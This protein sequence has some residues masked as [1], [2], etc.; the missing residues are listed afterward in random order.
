MKLVTELY[1]LVL[2]QKRVGMIRN[3]AI[4]EGRQYDTWYVSEV[5][6][7]DVTSAFNM[8]SIS[9]HEPANM[10]MRESNYVKYNNIKSYDELDKKK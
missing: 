6:S 7:V 9:A 3:E 4:E 2:L 10:F 5:V 1:L 8:S